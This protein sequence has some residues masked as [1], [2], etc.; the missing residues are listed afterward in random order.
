MAVTTTWEAIRDNYIR[1][2]KAVVPSRTIA[3]RYDESPRNVSIFEFAAR[4]GSAAIRRFQ[5]ERT[6]VVGDAPIIDWTAK[7]TNEDAM[8][9]V[10]YP[11][12]FGAYG[13]GDRND[14]DA[15]I[16][17]DARQIR[18]L[19]FSGGNY[20]AGQSAAFVTIDP[21]DMSDDRIWF[22]SFLIQLIYTESES[23]T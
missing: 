11:T 13:T 3:T 7:E 21:T 5:F 8:L 22:Q 20:L 14:L 19:L 9:V 15:L 10:A 16:R 6:G 12:A 17:A 1:L 4:A 2:L 23:L 18:D